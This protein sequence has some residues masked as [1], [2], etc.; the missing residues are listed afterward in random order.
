MGE[1]IGDRNSKKPSNGGERA[2]NSRPQQNDETPTRH[3]SSQEVVR[4]ANSGSNGSGSAKGSSATKSSQQKPNSAKG[5]SA[6]KSSQQKP[7]SAKGSSAA[8]SSQQKSNSA[9]NTSAAKSSKKRSGTTYSDELEKKR[10]SE[11]ERKLHASEAARNI[12]KKRRKRDYER[13]RKLFDFLLYAAIAVAVISV[14]LIMSI[15]VLFAITEIE[16]VA[17]ADVP[18]STGQIL[19]SC[20]VECGQNL[21]TAPIEEASEQIMSSLPYIESCTV[22]RQLPSTVVITA[23]AAKPVGVV[24]DEYGNSIIVSSGLRSLEVVVS[25]SD[26]AGMPVI[27]GVVIDALPIGNAIESENAAYVSTA[28]QIIDAFAEKS[29][30]LDEISF[31]SGGQITAVYDGRITLVFGTQSN[32]DDKLALAVSLLSEGK[33]TKHEAGRLDL[34]IDGRATFTP[35]Y[36]LNNLD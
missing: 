10:N 35:D 14:V 23:T 31:S 16:V 28:A 26:A 27:N 20:D 21:F 34:R 30:T 25:A 15:S 7:N 19:S 36:V 3:F 9:K 1:Y 33:I 6:A 18:Y 24:K 17:D 11:Y 12:K 13:H 8:K 4:R 22:K 32:L 5:S 29:M 2:K